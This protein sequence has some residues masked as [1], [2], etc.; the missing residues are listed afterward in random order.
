MN[1][2]LNQFHFLITLV[3]EMAHAVCTTK[4]G[5]RI[6]PHGPEWKHEFRKL[7]YP[8]IEDGVFPHEIASELVRHMKNPKA[9]TSSDHRLLSAIRSYDAPR[10]QLTVNDL[11]EGDRFSLE[12]RRIFEKGKKNRTRH[13]CKELSNG[14][15]YLISGIA[16]VQLVKD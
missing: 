7:L 5:W 16:E 14:R 9:S 2:S 6:K 3:H 13:V 8:H 12:G 4:H 15:T 10:D 1:N 11:K